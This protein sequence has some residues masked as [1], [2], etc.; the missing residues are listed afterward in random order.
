MRW[1]A[2]RPLKDW[3]K[4]GNETADVQPVDPLSLLGDAGR[5]AYHE[6]QSQPVPRAFVISSGGHWQYQVGTIP[7]D[8]SLPTDPAER[9]LALCNRR[10]FADCRLYAVDDRVVCDRLLTLPFNLY[11]LRA[12]PT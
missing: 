3:F 7:R 6:Y 10:G 9:A 1:L 8:A 11:S 4:P 2:E 5:N 12:C